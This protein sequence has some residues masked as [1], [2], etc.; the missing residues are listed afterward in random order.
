MLLLCVFICG[1]M[2]LPFTTKQLVFVRGVL[3]ELYDLN[4]TRQSE[5]V[6]ANWTDAKQTVASM[7]FTKITKTHDH[8]RCIRP[9]ALVEDFESANSFTTKMDDLLKWDTYRQ[10]VKE[11]GFPC[12]IVVPRP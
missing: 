2:C 8:D 10:Y 12:K 5:V 4:I 6:L 11:Y 7:L 3:D 9:M 1:C